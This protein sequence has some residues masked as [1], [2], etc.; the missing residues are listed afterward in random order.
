[1]NIKRTYFLQN[2]L[3]FGS[4][5]F[6]LRF[7]LTDQLEDHSQRIGNLYIIINTTYANIRSALT[8]LDSHRV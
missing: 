1:M 4:I 5:E 6:P 2:H 8:C 3:R 7:F